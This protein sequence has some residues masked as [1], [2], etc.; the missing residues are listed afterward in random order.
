MNHLATSQ[1]LITD[2]VWS[3][4]AMS[5][6][7]SEIESFEDVPDVIVLLRPVSKYLEL[8]VPLVAPPLPAVGSH[9]TGSGMAPQGQHGSSVLKS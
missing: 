9:R 8:V 2:T 3:S 7:N 5:S 6:T 4:I 1:N